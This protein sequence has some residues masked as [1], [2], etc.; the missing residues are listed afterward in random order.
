MSELDPNVEY[1]EIPGVEYHIV[2][3]DGSIWTRWHHLHGKRGVFESVLLD[4]WRQISQY[5]NR[6]KY[7]TVMLCNK[8]RSSRTVHSLV[9]LAFCGEKPE[10]MVSRH[11]DGNKEN[12]ALSN[13]LYGTPQ[14][15]ADDRI[16][17]GR[18]GKGELCPSSKLKESSVIDMRESFSNG[19]TIKSLAVRHNTT[20]G[21]VRRIVTGKSW[22][23]VSGPI[24][25]WVPKGAGGELH[26][27]AL[28]TEKD[29][30]RI[31]EDVSSGRKTISQVAKEEFA[32]PETIRD[33]VKGRSWQKVGGP[34]V[35]TKKAKEKNDA[36]MQC[37]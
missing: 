16:K 15:N 25:P 33:I 9:L 32:N 6:G 2:G 20:V 1:R 3:N 18:S 12:N 5:D 34:L 29:V 22:E 26:P 21:N 27:R 28:F 14:E 24:K 7:K 19:E 30:I 10:G 8:N 23:H 35:P 37:K 13:L 31:R 11:L 17:H 36:S 4:T